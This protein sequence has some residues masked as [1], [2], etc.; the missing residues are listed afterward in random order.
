MCLKIQPPWPMPRDT[1]EVGKIL[2]KPDSPYRLIG[3]KLFGRFHEQEYA[4]LYPAEGQPGLSPIILAFITVFQYLEKMSDRQAAEGIRVRIDWKYALHLPLEYAGFD[5]SV[6]SEFRDRLLKH[7][8]EERVFDKLVGEFR[9]MGLI[10]QRGRQ[11]SDS[12]A[13]LTKVRWLSRLELVI[14]TLRVTVGAILEANREWGEE[15]IPPSWEGR[16]GERFVMA[17]YSEKEWQDYQAH[18]GEDGQWLIAH[19]EGKSVPTE[20]GKLAEVQML[21]TVWAQQFREAEG[22]VVFRQEVNSDGHS[23]ISTPHDAEARYS[24]KRGTEWIGGKV[25]VTETDD[26]GYPHLITDI[27]ATSS[28][29]TDYKALPDIQ[30]R[31]AERACLPEKHYVDNA[32]MGGSNLANSAQQEID[33]IGPIYQSFSKQEQLADGLTIEQFSIDL[34]KGQAS[35]PAGVSVP[36]QMRTQERIRFHFPDAV[37]ATCPLRPRCCLGQSGRT[38]SVSEAYPLLQAARQRQVT[39]EFAHDYHQHRSGVEG[40]LSALVRG[41]GMR[42]SRYTSNRKRHLQTVFSATAANLKRTA[43]WLA[44]KRP[45]RY[46]QP[47]ELLPQPGG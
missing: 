18:I 33:L 25:Q 28:T 44:G 39:A 34:E 36:A 30:A 5:Y 42:T 26:A 11:R 46:R 20:I 12:I 21:K 24:K 17:R 14:E 10:K 9:G 1:G 47:W 2:L 40:C 7:Q 37:C 38:I 8:A 27:A 35:C 29:Q 41:S 31:L 4:D 6:L 43:R 32:Y 23:L 45:K 15:I 22:Q 19:L 3:D 16:Y 13:I